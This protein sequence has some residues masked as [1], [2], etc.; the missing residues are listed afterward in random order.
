MT[1]AR[2]GLCTGAEES[3][4][5]SDGGNGETMEWSEWWGKR[6]MSALV[7]WCGGTLE[8]SWESDKLGLSLEESWEI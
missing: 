5:M 8:E 3:E 2:E 7:Y 1:S 6:V 4:S